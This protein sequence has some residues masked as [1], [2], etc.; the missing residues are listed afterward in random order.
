MQKADLLKFRNWPVFW[1]ISLMPITAVGLII[2]GV[3]FLILPVIKDHGMEEKEAMLSSVVNVAYNMVAEYDK[4]VASGEF[5]L[6]EGQR[7]AATSIKDFRFGKDGKDYIWVSDM[8]PKMIMDPVKPELNGKDISDVK[9]PDGKALFLDMVNIVKNRGEGVIS[10]LWPRPGEMEPQQ[11]VSYVKGYKPWG[12]VIGG[13]SYTEDI[14]AVVYKMLMILGGMIVVVSVLVTLMTFIV[15]RGFVTKPMNEFKKALRMIA[16]GGGDLTKRLEEKSSDE[17]GGLVSEINMLLDSYGMMINNTLASAS[18]V[19]KNVG[20]LRDDAKV[21]SEGA[22]TQYNQ[23]HQIATA[24]EEMSQTVTDISKSASVALDVSNDAMKTADNGKQIS[25]GAVAS[26]NKV[27]SSTTDLSAMI[28]KLDKSVEEIGG[29]VIVITDIADQTNL[30]AL[31]AAI[32]AARAGEQGR[33]FA[34]VAD[35][36]RKLAEKTIKATSEINQKITA[37][38]HESE[39]TTKSMNTTTEEV[40]RANEYIKEVGKALAK[41]NESVRRAGD[42][43]SQIATAVEQQSA[44]A[45]EVARNIETTLLISK[46]TDDISRRVLKGANNIIGEVDNLRKASSGFKTG[47]SGIVML[48]IARSDHKAFLDNIDDV[49]KGN[50][51]W[52]SDKLHDSHNCRFGTWYDTEGIELFGHLATFKNLALPHE[53]VHTLAKDIVNKVNAG[54]KNTAQ[55]L[56]KEFEKFT[57]L[58]HEGIDAIENEYSDSPASKSAGLNIKAGAPA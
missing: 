31:N 43:I 52:T 6:E 35:E 49:I 9:D 55:S 56:Y 16:E 7:R 51:Q 32:E 42:Q 18:N 41:I 46:E 30:L 15:G 3:I 50:K 57:R 28:E 22:K 34:V 14:T 39:Q 45:K 36:V 8:V 24:A 37:V 27:F 17:I 23:A 12:W 1:K 48:E 53:R 33:G 11:K 54:D 19:V 20:A 44:A 29:I 47:G 21:M 5:T 4:R 38:Q 40:T 25:D 26:V 58:M 2:I 10:Y 13:G